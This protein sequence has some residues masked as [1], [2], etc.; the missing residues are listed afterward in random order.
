MPFSESGQGFDPSDA[1]DRR[2]PSTIEIPSS[3]YS[4]TYVRSSGPG[5]QKVNKTSS[6]A[7]LRWSVGGS[8]TFTDEEKELI[9]AHCNNRINKA[10]EIVL[11]NKEQRSQVQNRQNVIDILHTLVR[12]ALTPEAER[13]ATRPSLGAKKRRVDDKTKRGKIKKERGRDYRRDD[14]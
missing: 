11:H 1:R 6:K 9:R 7:E 3:E 14:E 12:K 13:V 4:I 10:D 8:E 2:D 5:G